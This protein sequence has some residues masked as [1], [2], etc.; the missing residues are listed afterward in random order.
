MNKCLPSDN[1]LE[2]NVQAHNEK[3]DYP[4]HNTSRIQSD[5]E[6]DN[7]HNKNLNKSEEYAEIMS[8]INKEAD[9]IHSLGEINIFD[10]YKSL[11]STQIVKEIKNKK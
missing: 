3:K 6:F 9:N 4:V 2:Q 5:T 7:S 11:T 10:K 8:K 1:I